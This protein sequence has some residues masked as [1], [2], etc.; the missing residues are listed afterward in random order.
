M[1]MA[2]RAAPEAAPAMLGRGT[3][4]SDGVS[5]S[6]EAV[7]H[8]LLESRSP[9]TL[10]LQ[11]QADPQGIPEPAGPVPASRQEPCSCVASAS[12]LGGARLPPLTIQ[13][14]P[15]PFSNPQ[16]V[17]VKKMHPVPDCG[18]TLNQPPLQ[19]PLQQRPPPSQPAPAA[20]SP[21]PQSRPTWSTPALP[22]RRQSSLG[23]PRVN[24]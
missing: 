16:T 6:A 10:P 15:P 5:P 24:E 13:P 8:D 18:P 4:I 21:A 9:S 23:P 20:T 14:R 11:Q 2:L 7:P 1:T 19:Q 3:V 12:L 17:G 22:P